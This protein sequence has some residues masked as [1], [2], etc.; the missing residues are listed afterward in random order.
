[1]RALRVNS[2]RAMLG[3]AL[4]MGGVACADKAFTPPSHA[5][6]N[7]RMKLMVMATS[8]QQ[9]A[10]SARYVWVAAAAIIPGGD[11][12][13]LAMMSVPATGG[14]QNITLDVDISR[15][16]AATAAKGSSGCSIIVAAAL[17]ADSIARTDTLKRDP[18][19][20][21]FDYVIVG[22][23][24]V[25]TGRAPTIPNIDL[26]VSRFSVFD[27][28]QDDAMRLGN[29]SFS[30]G[31]GGPLGRVLT[32]TASGTGNA[33]LYTVGAGADF[34]VNTNTNNPPAPAPVN[35]A[36]GIFE[37]GT[38]RRVLAT[39]APTINFGSNTPQGFMDVTALATNDVYLAATSGL[40]KYDGASFTKITTVTD[41]LYS[42]GSVNTAG[43]KLVVAG[44]PGG[45]VWIGYG[46]TW[47]RYNTG[48]NA[49]FDGVCINGA[50]EAFASSN[51]TGALYRFNG[52]AWTST[53]LQGNS[54]KF[55]LQCAGGQAFVTLFGGTGFYRYGAA[56]WS[57]LPTTG[58]N[59]S[60]NSRMAAVSA[61]EIYAVGDSGS[62]DRAFYRFDGTSW[63]EIGRRRFAQSPLKAW[64][65]PRGGA[66]YSA[67][68][69]GTLEKATPSGVS[70][71]SSL[72]S[73]RDAVMTSANSA[74]VVGWN[75]FL[76]R[77]D[78]ARWKIDPPPAGTPSVRILQGVWSDG[79]SNAWAVGGVNTILRYNGTAWSV[80][81]D[82]FR[83][84]T[85]TDNHNA[86]WGTGSDVWIA[87]DN[88]ILHCRS[89]TSCAVENSGGGTLYSVWG[90][91]ATNVFAVGAN[92]RILRYN[93]TSW[94]A[95]N[96]PTNRNLARV[97]GS[98]ANDVWAVGDS[99]LVHFDGTQWTNFP[100]NDDLRSIVTRV[101]AN[102]QAMFQMGLWV[103]GP[104]EAY[105]GGDAGVIVRWDGSGWRQTRNGQFFFGR[106]V[107]AITGAAGCA[108][109]VTDGQSDV[110]SPTLWRGVG[111]NGCLTS[112]MGTPTN[113]P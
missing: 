1:M 43:G 93:G 58:L 9:V 37:N 7:A 28:E 104:K 66:V 112:P 106:R 81:S 42:V 69:F 18:F 44:G 110:P 74:F 113:W 88:S 41:S 108:M 14:T 40:Y 53:P 67:S 10:P 60:R 4:V 64:A 97:A 48:T 95:M 100:L 2:V 78:G 34:S 6:V 87:G 24:D 84:I 76:A 5:V 31:G 68:A 35:P 63:T 96:S 12:G 30:L 47:Q 99:V 32:G 36:L 98:G 25:S 89:V 13:L 103:K 54:S 46:T 73:L 109:A 65:D 26:S 29:G 19:V 92:G 59:G 61:S 79:P 3:M 38:W 45:I 27:W 49:R 102:Q 90:S 20:R 39:S 23:F 70:L 80:V 101:P 85:S 82:Q 15:C 75:L 16:V 33:V 83:P 56:G 55:D 94:T 105:V 107:L 91:S 11:T 57:P 72:P 50:S 86:V 77:W 8:A 52:T 21:S 71:L 51:T 22:P 111:V 62:T 17:R